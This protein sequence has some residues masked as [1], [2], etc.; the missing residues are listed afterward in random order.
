[1]VY[2][3]DTF[4]QD[5]HLKQNVYTISKKQKRKRL[6]GPQAHAL[7]IDDINSDGLKD[8]AAIDRRDSM[9]R[10]FLQDMA[11]PG[12]FL[13][14]SNHKAGD[15]PVDIAIGDLDE[16]GIKDIAV[17]GD[18]LVLLMNDH[19]EPGSAFNQSALGISD[20]TSV[21]ISD[22][23][24]DGR[25]DLTAVSDD[26]I[27]VLLQDLQ[28]AA[29]G[30]F[31]S[32]SFYAAG[33]DAA[34][35]ATGDLNNDSLQDIVVVNRGDISGSVTVYMQDPLEVGTF[36]AGMS[37]PTGENSQAIAIDDLNGDLLPDLVVADNG[38]GGGSVSILLQN[39]LTQGVF[40]PADT[41]PGMSGPN[42]VATSDVNGDG[43]TDLVIAD[44]CTRTRNKPYFRYQD[45]NNPGKF[46]YPIHFP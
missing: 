4:S 44:K 29:P 27:V 23:N 41:Y 42:D 5:A 35:V 45:I 46:L 34:D 18:D 12:Q 28:P 6:Y 20:V 22:L 43:L 14:R 3:H 31:S 2:L 17:A 37:Y 8:I 9:V 19:V 15:R 36:H 25:N 7:A 13:P 38:S 39:A 21:V 26:S 24:G 30:N 33:I 32:K 1:M 10:V 11:I 16:D 40:L